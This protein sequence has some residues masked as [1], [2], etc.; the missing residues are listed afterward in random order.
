MVRLSQTTP[1]TKVYLLGLAAL[2]QEAAEAPHLIP[3]FREILLLVPMTL[4]R[5]RKDTRLAA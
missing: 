1:S 4:A 5:L 2:C 3:A